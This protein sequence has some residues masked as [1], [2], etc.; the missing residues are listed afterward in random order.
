MKPMIRVL[1]DWSEIGRVTGPLRRAELP[2][3]PGV[4][5]NWDHALL[6]AALEGVNRDAQIIDLGCGGGVTL[7]F[8]AALGFRNIRGVDLH[9]PRGLRAIK[10]ALLNYHRLTVSFRIDRGDLTATAYPDSCFDF[11]ACISTIEHGVDL[12]R[13]FREARRI[14]RPNAPLFVT[15][16]YWAEKIPTG[17]RAFGLSWRIFSKDEIADLIRVAGQHGFRL[18]EPGE[19]PPCGDRPIH[20]N[21]A[22]YTFIALLFRRST[23]PAS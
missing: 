23:D 10:S 7:E 4:E 18:A 14:L 15:T 11:G 21:G 22:D 19:I 9:V 20:W 8:L 13:F 12:D 5:K 6:R 3:Y 1:Q 17:A 2:L 16:D